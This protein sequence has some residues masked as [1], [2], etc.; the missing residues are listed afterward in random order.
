MFSVLGYSPK[1]NGRL[2]S[3]LNIAKKEIY[4]GDEIENQEV[5]RKRVTGNTKFC[6]FRDEILLQSR[7][8]LCLHLTYKLLCLFSYLWPQY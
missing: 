1:V 8:S 3:L 6:L 7:P 4:V 5:D 2:T